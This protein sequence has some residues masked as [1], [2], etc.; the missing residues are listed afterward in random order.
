MRTICVAV[1][2]VPLMCGAA[3]AAEPV[4]EWQVKNGGARI[5]IDSCVN[6]L[7]GYISWVRE[8]GTD[9]KNPDPAKRSRPM[10]G[11]PIVRGLKQVKPNRWQGE[12]YNA[13]NGKIYSASATLLNDDNLRIEGCVLGGLFC[14]GET[15]TR[16]QQAATSGS[17]PRDSAAPPQKV[18]YDK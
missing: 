12:V 11:V 1:I 18:C 17:G 14:G 6:G 2:M 8:P 4:G 10:V 15:W 5:R 16:V 7:W 13:Q 3:G 9:S